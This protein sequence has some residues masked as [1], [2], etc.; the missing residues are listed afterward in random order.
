MPVTRPIEPIDYLIIGHVTQDLTSNGPTLGGTVSYAAL[1]AKA[2]G[3]RV[4]V[5]TA[6]A[7]D[8]QIP[9]LEGIAIYSVES[10]YTST[11]ENIQTPNGRVQYLHAVAAPLSLAS[12]PETWRSTPI[13]HLGPLC[14]EVDPQLARAFPNS[15]VGV[16]PQG[17]FRSWD[18]D[19]RVHFTEW[20]EMRFVLENVSATVLS[21][22]DIN[23]NETLVEE[24]ASSSRILVVTEGP[25]GA[26]LY[27]NGDL[28]RFMPPI[29]QEVDPTG[30]GD[31]FATSFFIRMYQTRDPW[32]S[33]RFATQIAAHSV[34]RRGLQGVPTMDEV[35]SSL[36]EVLPKK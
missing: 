25:A 10:D 2:L 22:E 17:W 7:P 26:R 36:I 27:W 12:V 13:I 9:E 11:F 5:V 15:I 29:M 32:E 20:P 24:M 18:S 33:A 31:I 14:Q 30:A 19:H 21:I 34:T 16:T 8:L 4:G 28:R 6:H 3:L 23:K 1:T 35:Y